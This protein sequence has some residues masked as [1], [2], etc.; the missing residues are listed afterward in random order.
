[1]K[2][3][4]KIIFFI[5]I[6]YSSVLPQ[7]KGYL[8]MIGGG[9]RPDYLMKRFIELA[10]GCSSRIIIIA[11]AS[12]EPK[13]T[14]LS[15][16]ESFE[17]LGCN[18]LDFIYNVNSTAATDSNL[19]KLDNARGIFFTGGDQNRLISSLLNTALLEKIKL[20]YKDGGVIGGTSAGAA[21]MSKI[22]ITGDELINS[23]STNTF[24]IIKAGN[25]KTSIGFGFIENAIIDQHFVSRKRHNR[26]ISLVLEHPELVGIG[27]DESTA[28]IFNPDSTVEILGE[29]LVVL[30][31]AT[32]T[33]SITKDKNGNLAAD[34]VKLS[35]LK[36]GDIYNLKTQDIL[37]SK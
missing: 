20:I 4:K 25:V 29:N 31:N 27:I 16:M 19:Q 14:A 23:D 26:L 17:Q 15:Q 5:L 1:M 7:N 13:E 22:M 11:I 3:I 36:S 8:F 18:K 24:S 6:L 33:K 10:G 2:Q 28:C 12:S 32:K 35:I 21:I 30:Y 34:N 9:E 37:I